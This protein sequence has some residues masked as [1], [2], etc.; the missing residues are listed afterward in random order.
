MKC[1][2]STSRM[3]CVSSIDSGS[4]SSGCSWC[5]SVALSSTGIVSPA[6]S[7]K[8]CRITQATTTWQIALVVCSVR[9]SRLFHLLLSL[10]KAISTAILLWLD[11]K[12]KCLWASVRWPLS[13]YG[14]CIQLRRGC[15]GS[16]KI[17][18]GMLTPAMYFAGMDG[19]RVPS[20]AFL[21]N[22]EFAK[23][24]A[25][26]TLPGTHLWIFLCGRQLPAS[27]WNKILSNYRRLLHWDHRV[28]LFFMCV[29]S[30]QLTTCGKPHR[31]RKETTICLASLAFGKSTKMG[32]KC[33]QTAL[34]TLMWLHAWLIFLSRKDELWSGI[35]PGYSNSLFDTDCFWEM[36]VSLLQ[37]RRK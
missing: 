26:W 18:R 16:A 17:N 35:P 6:H 34:K 29:P 22:P 30:R 36:H 37:E 9:C 20:S 10:P 5:I 24:Q 12:F 27:R 13:E 25:S 7:H 1:C 33:W 31:W 21:N 3:V 8:L 23:T 19:N 15:A 11:L 2:V 28:D 4:I 14:F 32:C